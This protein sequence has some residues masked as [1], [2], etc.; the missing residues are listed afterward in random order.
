MPRSLSQCGV[1]QSSIP[2]LAR[3]ASK[4]WTAA[5]NPRPIAAADFAGLFESAFGSGK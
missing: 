4:Q 2:V 3:E 1:P 5:F